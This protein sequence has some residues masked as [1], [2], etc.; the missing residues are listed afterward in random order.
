MLQSDGFLPSVTTLVAGEVMRSSWWSHPL[1]HDIFAVT[2]QLE[3]HPDVLLTKL[4]SNKVTFVHRSLWR[5]I[6]AIGRAREEW[7]MAKLSAPARLLLKKLDK[8][9]SLT[10]NK[11]GPIFG[12]KPGDTARELETR[13]LIHAE[14][15]HTA[16]G[17]HSKLLETWDTWVKRHSFKSPALTPTVAKRKIEQHLQ[18]LNEQFKGD[19]ILPWQRRIKKS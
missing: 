11:L 9:G 7:Q 12:T 2:E 4:V 8:D 14:Q 13:L 15:F 10:S 16:S 17:T 1:S 19:G 3:D 6:L 5:P 18:V